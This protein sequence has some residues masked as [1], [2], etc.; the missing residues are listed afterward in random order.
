MQ[1]KTWAFPWA[2]LRMLVTEG[3]IIRPPE[4]ALSLWNE[5]AGLVVD[6]RSMTVVSYAWP[7]A[8]DT[9]ELRLQDFAL[10][11][12][13]VWPLDDGVAMRLTCLYDDNMV[14]QW[15]LSTEKYLL[16]D[17]RRWIADRSFAS[18]FHEAWAATPECASVVLTPGYTHR[19][20]LLH[21]DARHVT[22][23]DQ[24]RVVYTGS[25][26]L[27]TFA[28]DWVLAMP[29][30][31]RLSASHLG[32]LISD[33]DDDWMEAGLHVYNAQHDTLM[34]IKHPSHDHVAFLKGNTV[35][36][37]QRVLD[38]VSAG[39]HGEFVSYYP[40]YE[41]LVDHL[42]DF[43]NALELKL[44]EGTERFHVWRSTKKRQPMPSAWYQA[45]LHGT[46]RAYDV[47]RHEMKHRFPDFLDRMPF[48]NQGRDVPHVNWQ[49][50]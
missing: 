43:Y 36:M 48:W 13:D 17:E 6:V 9:P 25:R 37:I 29:T 23:I 5:W 40:E 44:W 7:S 18:L 14:A 10:T 49:Y 21:P 11:S 22:P 39:L 34:V 35:H 31:P 12:C 27:D 42:S 16:A 19:F 33:L 50:L 38:L 20:S 1:V 45:F 4:V 32:D 2:S 41:R 46:E 30:P 8:H 26:R 47:W 15:L 24:P 3:E 28:I